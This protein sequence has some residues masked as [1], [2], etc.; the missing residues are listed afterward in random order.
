M[1]AQEM[2]RE[3]FAT[4]FDCQHGGLWSSGDTTDSSIKSFFGTGSYVKHGSIMPHR[5]YMWIYDDNTSNPDFITHNYP[6][7]VIYEPFSEC[8][9]NL[10]VVE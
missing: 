4:S 9:V 7:A 3:F 2:I 1:K 10:Y 6:Q 5:M 8:N